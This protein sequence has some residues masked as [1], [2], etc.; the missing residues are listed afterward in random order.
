MCQALD[1]SEDSD[2]LATRLHTASETIRRMRQ[3]DLKEVFQAISEECHPD[4]KIALEHATVKG[5]IS[6]L[7]ILPSEYYDFRLN[8]KLFQR[9]SRYIEPMQSSTNS[10]FN[11]SYIFKYIIIGDMGVGK[12]CVLH[13]FTERKFI[14]DCPHTIGVEFGTRIIEVGEHKIKLQIWDTAG[15]ERFR[16][17]TRS[18]YRGSAGCLLVYDI[19]RRQTFNNLITWLTDAK[20]L[21]SNNT[22]ILLIG[23]KSDLE[24]QRDV[25][26]DEAKSFADEH[27][28]VFFETSART[29]E[30]VESAFLDIAS[31]IYKKIKEGSIDINAAETGVQP[32]PQGSEW[33][34]SS[35]ASDSSKCAC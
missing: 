2:S 20:A 15:Q 34:P 10:P 6:W 9:R 5:A 17:V 27:G 11:Y 22:V 24:T 3:L 26:Y 14:P 12:S 29:G 30:N 16:A 19:T 13:Y 32:R 4:R 28:L 8:D 7:N 33:S 31:N 35:S 23:N 1:S 18:Y 21:T 25:S